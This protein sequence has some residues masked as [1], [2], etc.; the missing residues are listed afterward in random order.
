MATPIF[1]PEKYLLYNQQLSKQLAIVMVIEGIPY[2]FGIGDVYE[3]VK[4]GTPGLYWGL[5]GLIW[6]GLKKIGG[7][8][9]AA[10]VKAYVVLDPAMTIQ[11]RIEPEQGRGNIGTIN[12]TLIDYNGEI[13]YMI[14]PGNVVDEIMCGKQTTIYVGFQQ[15]SFPQDYLVL[16]RGYITSLD[17]PP[18]IVRFQISDGTMK[19]RQP[20]SNTPSTLIT[21]PLDDTQ[22]NIPVISTSGFYQQIMGPDG[23]YS[24]K[25]HTYIQVDEE[26]MEYAFDGIVDSENF[27]VTRGAL[28]T[29]PAAHDVDATVTNSIQLGF[30]SGG[31]GIN[32]ID[33]ALGLLLS[34]R[35]GPCE[36][37]LD[38]NSCGL[39]GTD[40]NG[41]ILG[42]ND[43]LQLDAFMTLG[44]S[45]GDYFY[46]TGATDPLNDIEGVITNIEYDDNGF[47]SIVQTDTAFNSYEPL[48]DA[49]VSFRSKY[50]IFPVGIG[51]KARMRDV[52]VYTWELIRENYFLAAIY[53]VAV[54]YNEPVFAKETIAED[55]CL[56]MGCY[57][58]SR[59]GRVSVSVTK[60]PL[61]GSSQTLVQLDYTNVLDPD[62]IHVTRATNNRTFYNQIS[63]EY[64]QNPV[65]GAF[66]TIQYFIDT[67]SASLFN[68][69]LTLPI[70]A[71]ALYS[72]LGSATVTTNRGQALLAR[73]KDVALMLELTVNWSA[74]SQIEVSDIVL[75]VD[76]GN[77]KIMNFQT[78]ER[79]I[80]SQLFEVIDRT[81]MVSQGK[82]KLKVLSGLNFNINSRFGLIA[83]STVLNMGCTTTL[84]RLTPS[85]GQTSLAAE[86][87]KWTPYIGLPIVVHN[88]DF[89]NESVSVIQGISPTD[90]TALMI[91]PALSFTPAAGDILEI[92]DYPTTTSKTEN[93]QYKALYAYITPTID[94]VSGTSTTVFEVSAPDAL[95]MTVGNWVV[96]RKEDY[97]IYTQEVNVTDITGTTITVSAALYNIDTDAPI[98]PDNTYVVEGIGFKDLTGAYRYT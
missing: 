28:G 78:G 65:T 72:S 1:Y 17:T 49:T 88:T 86:M 18:G 54:Y 30:N 76:N 43:N 50:D 29:L 19:S 56:P 26:V 75:I 15:T 80:G 89:S 11:Q 27:T 93:S 83:P 58:I 36:E 38:L 34:G 70:Q 95:K 81:F 85:F 64:D 53:E 2:T 48:T 6:G 92:A 16:Y 8:N 3:I 10:G 79:N 77:L 87:L 9:G 13:S 52:D 44:L 73:Y 71:R 32:F 21:T 24:D 46:V 55:L 4:W 69:V 47:A 57:Q 63:Y 22:T 23:T 14:A 33:C 37:D 67:Q 74:G 82:V 40:L 96:L 51:A 12:M 90:P 20:I 35:N 94:V 7:P 31:S 91:S 45:P 41:L 5:P 25:V 59:F 60:P 42:L 84:L 98:T 97:S 62:Q 68:Q 39:S 61:P 66:G